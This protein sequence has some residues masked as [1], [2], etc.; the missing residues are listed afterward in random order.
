MSVEAWLQA[1][2]RLNTQEMEVAEAVF[3]N[4]RGGGLGVCDLGESI[5]V[6]VKIRVR[7]RVKVRVDVIW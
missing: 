6:R 4:D 3:A 2:C 5:E 7:V 1:T